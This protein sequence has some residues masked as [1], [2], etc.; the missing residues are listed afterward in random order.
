MTR[1]LILFLLLLLP[2][3]GAAEML[4]STVSQVG[5][6]MAKG[7]DDGGD[8]DSDSDSD[9]DEE[10]DDDSD[11]G[12]DDEDDDQGDD[13][14]G[15]DDGNDDDGGGDDGGDDNDGG[16]GSDDDGRDN[17][18]RDTSGRGG[19]SSD[20]GLRSGLRRI[21]VDGQQERITGGQYE[22]LDRRGRVIERRPASNGDR[23]RLQ[24]LDGQGLEVIVDVT[25]S[26]IIVTDRAGWREEV[27]G[28]RYRL[29]DPRGNV[30]TRRAVTERDLARLR[31]LL[32]G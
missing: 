24:N 2:P 5:A 13:S 30:V 16:S 15:D 3:L 18:D 19:H 20:L 21:Y 1:R 6:A 8:D 25:P 7:G 26:R 27:Q 28:A 23:R 12:S 9:D 29:T 11:D 17:S 32:G 14:G 22:R 31:T 4:L 10:D